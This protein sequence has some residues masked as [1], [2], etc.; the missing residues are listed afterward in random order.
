[1]LAHV[2]KRKAFERYKQHYLSTNGQL[3]WS[4]THQLGFYNDKYNEHLESALPDYPKGSLMITEAY[5][6][7]ENLRE[8]MKNVANDSRKYGVNIIYGTVRLIEKDEESFLTWAKED[9]ACVIFNLRVEHSKEGLK[10]SREDFKRIIDRALELNGSYYLTYHRWARK[11]QILNSY[12][13]FA[14]FLKL[15]LKYD[16]EER[17]QSAWYRHYKRMFAYEIAN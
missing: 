10:K 16:S 8:F 14:E 3:Y 15:K 2:D 5:V 9:Y 11:D 4:D 7:R 13:Q 12:P 17:F 1:M 6:P